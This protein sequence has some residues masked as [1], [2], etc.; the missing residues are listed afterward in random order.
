MYSL[1]FAHLVREKVPDAK[2]YE[3]YIDMRAFGK[4]YEEFHERIREEGVHLLRG[5]SNSIVERDGQMYVHGE[6]I[7]SNRL[8]DVPVDMV[9]L[10]VGLQPSKGAD[11]LAGKL[12]IPRDSDGWFRE[13]NYNAE[14]NSTGRDGIYLAGVCQGPKDIPDTVAQA[15]AAAAY[16]LGSIVGAK[17]REATKVEAK[18]GT[19]VRS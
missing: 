5:R 1:K 14:P 17:S 2:C 9:V 16:V 13:L 15:S 8:I 3:F 6:D 19:P 11:E 7:A 4:G 12:N 18:A 10:S